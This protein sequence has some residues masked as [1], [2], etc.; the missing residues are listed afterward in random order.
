MPDSQDT[1]SEDDTEG[2]VIDNESRISNNIKRI[3]QVYYVL[4]DVKSFFMYSIIVSYRITN[5]I[6]KT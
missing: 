2:N 6:I 3:I 4:K 1:E 5:F